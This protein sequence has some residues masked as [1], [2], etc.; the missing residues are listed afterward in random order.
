MVSALVFILVFIPILANWRR[1][2]SAQQHPSVI[3]DYL[4]KEVT[5][6]RVLRPTNLPPIFNLHISCF[7]V[8]PKKGS[9]WRLILDHSVNLKRYTMEGELGQKWHWIVPGVEFVRIRHAIRLYIYAI[10]SYLYVIGSYLNAIRSYINAIG[11]Y[12]YAIC[13]YPRYLYAIGS[14]LRY[15]YAIGSYLGYLYAIRSSR[16]AKCALNS[17][18]LRRSAVVEIW[19][20]ST[21]SQYNYKERV[22]GSE[23]CLTG[24]KLKANN[25]LHLSWFFFFNNNNI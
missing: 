9:G 10:G 5:L 23:E 11:S 1:R 24:E 13:S 14:Y 20:I 3:D 4:K 8:I 22:V 2:P 6:G 12:L 17:V 25:I 18:F 7:G 16:N 15:L 21:S 19:A